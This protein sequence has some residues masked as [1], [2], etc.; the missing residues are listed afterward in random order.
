MTDPHFAFAEL[1]RAIAEA[2]P[3]RLPALLAAL[4]ARVGTAAARILENGAA[5]GDHGREGADENLTV[6]E[7]ARRLGMSVAWT[8]KNAHR[9]PFTVRV[10]RRAVRFSARRLETYLRHRQGQGQ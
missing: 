2:P 10:G 7:A 4:S 6:E 8:Y 1:D 3:E 9:L 5:A